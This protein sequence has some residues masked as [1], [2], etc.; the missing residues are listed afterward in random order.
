MKS[1]SLHSLRSWYLILVQQPQHQK[2]FIIKRFWVQYNYYH[3]SLHLINVFNL[4]CALLTTL[5]DIIS[6]YQP[7]LMMAK[8][9]VCQ[10]IYILRIV[11]KYPFSVY[12]YSSRL[13]LCWH[14]NCFYAYVCLWGIWRQKLGLLHTF[15]YIFTYSHTKRK[16]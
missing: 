12:Y 13:Q 5:F 16:P 7:F 2:Y 3:Q 15:L 4:E 10:I 14:K 9:N 1:K 11:I 6:E 8:K